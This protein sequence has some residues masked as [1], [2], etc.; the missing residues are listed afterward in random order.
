MF[1]TKDSGKRAEFVTGMVRDIEDGKPRF[2][3]LWPKG[4]PFAKQMQTRFAELMAR[5]ADKYTERNWEKARTQEELDRYYSSAER[6]LHQ[7]KAGETD[8][9]H[10]AAV[11]FNIM[12]AETVKYHMGEK[13]T[14]LV[15]DNEQCDAVDK[16]GHRCMLVPLHLDMHTCKGDSRWTETYTGALRE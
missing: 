13:V 4:V 10:A 16:E 5:G 7:W 3:L 6:H 12:A 8:E 14:T 11:M 1:D 9:D 2:D 15:V